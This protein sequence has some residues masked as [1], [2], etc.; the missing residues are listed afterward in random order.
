[1]FWSAR[2]GYKSGVAQISET[3]FRKYKI[4]KVAEKVAIPLQN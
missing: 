4:K 1:M 2:Q 3:K